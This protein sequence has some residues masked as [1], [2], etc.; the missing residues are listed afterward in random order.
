LFLLVE[1]LHRLHEF[2]GFSRGE[3]L[4][5]LLVDIVGFGVAIVFTFGH[6]QGGVS[7]LV[8]IRL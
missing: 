8:H 6:E 1:R 2:G 3:I 7:V 5:Q 4:A